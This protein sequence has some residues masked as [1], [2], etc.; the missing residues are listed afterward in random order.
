MVRALVGD[1]TMTRVGPPALPPEPFDFAFLL[2]DLPRFVLVLVAE[3]LLTLAVLAI[4]KP[5]NR[6]DA[7]ASLERW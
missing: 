6:F 7:E 2:V 3:V 5:F 1:S 4:C